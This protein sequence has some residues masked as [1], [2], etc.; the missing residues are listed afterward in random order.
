M[1]HGKCSDFSLLSNLLA[2]SNHFWS[3][4]GFKFLGFLGSSRRVSQPYQNNFKW[5]IGGFFWNEKLANWAGPISIA[6][7]PYQE[8][9]LKISGQSVH[10]WPPPTP[11]KFRPPQYWRPK[12]GG[13]PIKLKLKF[14]YANW[15]CR[16]QKCLWNHCKS[17]NMEVLFVNSIDLFGWEFFLEFY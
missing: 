17:S 2:L 12:N 1:P 6:V 7:V 16:F 11:L 9:S 5:L 13:R 15:P 4:N 14:Y 10:K 3:G 8:V